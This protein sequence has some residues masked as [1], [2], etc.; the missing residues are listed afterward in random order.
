M[1]KSNREKA[2]IRIGNAVVDGCEPDPADLELAR[3]SD[4]GGRPVGPDPK[5]FIERMNFTR[6]FLYARNAMG[7]SYD[8]AVAR[9]ERVTGKYIEKGLLYKYCSYLKSGEPPADEGL[10]AFLNY[11]R[12]TYDK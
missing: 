4:K 12:S 3:R 9:T 1:K 6:V 2:L 8:D 10:K 11:F 5:R 7:M